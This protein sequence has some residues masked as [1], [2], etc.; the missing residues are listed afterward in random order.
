MKLSVFRVYWFAL[1]Y[2]YDLVSVQVG[3]SF[4]ISSARSGHN[5]ATLHQKPNEDKI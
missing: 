2:N 3:N 4:Y 1:G 5:V